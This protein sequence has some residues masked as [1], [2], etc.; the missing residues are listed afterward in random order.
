MNVFLELSYVVVWSNCNTSSHVPYL[1]RSCN[2]ELFFPLLASIGAKQAN[3]IGLLINY[4]TRLNVS[5]YPQALAILSHQLEA[6]GI[7]VTSVV[8]E[9]LRALEELD[10]RCYQA[11]SAKDCLAFRSH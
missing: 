3:N 6:S 1:C 7:G 5:D 11:D 10:P 4:T 9:W 2:I 8:G